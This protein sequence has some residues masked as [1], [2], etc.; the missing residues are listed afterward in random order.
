[1]VRLDRLQGGNVQE[2][3]PVVPR[4]RQMHAAQGRV[5]GDARALEDIRRGQPHRDTGRII[6][7]QRHQFDI[8]RQ[9][10]SDVGAHRSLTQ[11]RRQSASRRKKG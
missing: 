6:G 1:M 9:L 3:P 11:L 2:L 5:H 10:L 4:H 7:R 8:G